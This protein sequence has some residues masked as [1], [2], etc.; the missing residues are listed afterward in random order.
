VS[1][2][3]NRGTIRRTTTRGHRRRIEFHGNE[4][5]RIVFVAHVVVDDP[6]SSTSPPTSTGVGG[7]R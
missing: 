7:R 2:K 6:A 3:I 1:S 4:L 5:A